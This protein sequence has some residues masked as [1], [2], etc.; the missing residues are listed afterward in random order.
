VGLYLVIPAVFIAAMNYFAVEVPP[1]VEEGSGEKQTDDAINEMF[2]E[3][4]SGPQ[5][6]APLPLVLCFWAY[7]ILLSVYTRY[8]R[9]S[10]RR[11][12]M[13]R[14]YQERAAA[15]GEEEAVNSEQLKLFLEKNRGDMNAAHRFCG[16]YGTDDVFFNDDGVA[17]SPLGN[18]T[19]EEEMMEG[20]FCTS[21]WSC[22]SN[23]FWASCCACWCQC[24]SIC[25]VWQEEMEVNRLTGNEHPTF[26][27]VTFQPY[28][29]YYPAIQSLKEHQTKS[30]WKHMSTLSELS[31]KL[32]KSL[33][34]VLVVL[35]LFALSSIDQNFTWENM[36][37]LLL[38][39]GQAFFI[40]YLVHW[41]WCKFDL[42][43]DS[44]VKYFACGFLLTTPMA[45][46]FEAI[47]STVA[48]LLIMSM[49]M[50]ILGAD[51]DI[52]NELTNDP[53]SALKDFAMKYQGLFIFYVFI[54]SFVVAAVTEEMVKYFGYW[55]VVVPDL[56]PENRSAPATTVIT[57]YDSSNDDGETEDE[58]NNATT[59]RKSARSTGAGITVAMVSVALGFACC[60]NLMYIFVYSPPSLGVEISTLV[61]RSLF[62]VHPLCAAIQSI[63]VCKRDIE[64]DKKYGIGRIISPAVLLHGSF[65]FVLMLAAFYES[66]RASEEGQG[67][68][69]GQEDGNDEATTEDLAAELPSL[70]SGLVFVLIGCI[71]YGFASRA[72]NQ[73]LIA[74]DNAATDQSSLLV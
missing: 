56:L 52:A 17:P 28:S 14:L 30:L 5:K 62:P 35:L 49:V 8:Q 48:S 27:Y 37:V 1:S 7:L 41:R 43:F 61:A 2:G 21:L 12:I 40:E 20:D 34:F 29:E 18:Q 4:H 13:K 57:S 51:Q 45:I 55:M 50:L 19:N 3:E 16:C 58:G 64:G 67:E 70:I 59:M 15:R 10:T 23:T 22:L 44:V 31:V 68:N 42:S 72:Q 60:E 33:G 32:L 11:E 54:N 6:V 66:L 65:D 46:A 63:G 36:I 69:Q 71:Y 53:K 73:R 47:I 24:C 74:M 25:A 38:T 26:D 9:Q 39:L